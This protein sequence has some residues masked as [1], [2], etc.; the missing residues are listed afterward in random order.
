[1][2]RYSP[3]C[4]NVTVVV[5]SRR[6]GRDLGR[7]GAVVRLGAGPVALVERVVADEPLVVDGVGVDQHERDRDAGRGDHLGRAER[8]IAHPDLGRR[9]GRCHARAARTQASGD[10]ARAPQR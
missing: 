2:K 10:P 7:A 6:P 9:A 4:W 8:R 3:G 5:R 1:M